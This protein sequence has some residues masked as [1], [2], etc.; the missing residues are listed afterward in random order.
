M[1]LAE[2]SQTPDGGTTWQLGKR[3]L[4]GHIILLIIEIRSEDL[5]M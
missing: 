5:Y 2:N 4:F 3:T 1:A